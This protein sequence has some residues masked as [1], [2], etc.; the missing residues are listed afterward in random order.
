MFIMDG[1]SFVGLS[2][3]VKINCHTVERE[4]RYNNCQRM[5]RERD[6]YNNCQVGENYSN[7]SVVKHNKSCTTIRSRCWTGLK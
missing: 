4:I 2:G 6:E 3:D 1:I 7:I 5:V